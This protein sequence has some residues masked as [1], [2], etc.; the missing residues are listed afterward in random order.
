L[1]LKNA[2]F[3]G[4]ILLLQIRIEN[5]M[6]RF[7]PFLEERNTASQVQHSALMK[8]KKEDFPFAMNENSIKENVIKL[9]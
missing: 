5:F 9:A 1:K 6:T 8:D 4:L 7:L 3:L 2:S